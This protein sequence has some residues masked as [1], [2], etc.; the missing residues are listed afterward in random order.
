MR[1]EA[2]K[3]ARRAVGGVSSWVAIT[4]LCLASAGARAEVTDDHHP[5]ERKDTPSD[6]SR[7]PV[8]LESDDRVEPPILVYP[9]HSTSNAAAPLMLLHGMCGHPE[10]ECPWFAGS[11]TERRWVACPRADLSCGGG[12]SIW[13]GATRA[14]KD[15]V[16]TTEARLEKAFEGAA[17]WKHGGILAGFSLGAFVALDVAEASH[18]EWK[19][20]ML[21]GAFVKPNAT[22]LKAAGVERVLFASGDWD[23]SR[24]EMKKQARALDRGGVRARYMGMGPVGH[25]FAKDMDSWLAEAIGWLEEESRD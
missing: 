23:M 11:A 7:H 3:R 24:D 21:I 5:P 22:K 8:W 13:S 1:F 16:S 15:L 14:R 6:G 4:I 10:N 17:G 12:G 2:V 20:L 19:R 25:W 9:P 18:G